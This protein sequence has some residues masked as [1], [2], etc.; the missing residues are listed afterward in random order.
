MRG[1][2]DYSGLGLG[3]AFASG[4]LF[5][6]SDVYVRLASTGLSPRK[7]LLISLLVGSPLLWAAALAL[8]GEPPVPEALLAYAAAGLLNFG[9]GRLLFYLAIA[10]S[11]VATASVLT[12]PTIV[13]ASL[14]AWALLGEP[15]T[16]RLAL[17]LLL[18]VGGVYLARARPSGEPLH[19]GSHLRGVVAGLAS[20]LAFAGSSVL[21]RYAGGS[22]GGSP[23]Y[24]AAISYTTAIPLALLLALRDGGGWSPRHAR[25]MVLGAA[26]VA[27]AQLSRYVALSIL[28]VA[29]ASV[30]IALF[31]VHTVVFA[32]LMAR[33]LR[34]RVGS[35]HALGAL[36]GF[37]GVAVAIG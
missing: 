31:P 4:L 13:V 10:Y 9:V 12:T 14:L 18:V 37:A 20:T 11:G 1:L 8:G 26:L 30:L 7:N 34:E 32:R 28:P 3:S 36:L 2:P 22:L 19:G 17:G 35:V 25:A 15:L 5:G 16:P 6:A 24:G 27:L 29:V 33:E 21:V 23:L